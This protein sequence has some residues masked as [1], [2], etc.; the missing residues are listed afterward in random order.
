ML[1]VRPCLQVAERIIAEAEGDA[2]C[3]E[4]LGILGHDVA[5]L[6]AD[7]IKARGSAATPG[8]AFGR[9]FVVLIILR[10]RARRRR[11][12]TSAPR[13]RGTP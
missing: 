10:S 4:I 3:V 9:K 7:I 5:E 12:R 1:A 6:D 8:C 2:W 11:Q 13:S